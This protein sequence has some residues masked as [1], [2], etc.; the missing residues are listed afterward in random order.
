MN[1][2]FLFDSPVLC[3]RVADRLVLTVSRDG[4]DHPAL[5]QHPLPVDEP[6][7]VAID[8]DLAQVTQAN[9]VLIGW[10]V[11]LV[12]L[13]GCPVTLLNV[14]PRVGMILRRMNLHALMTI[15]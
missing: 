13:C 14:A 2:A 10:L 1:T 15:A 7:I 9:S 11:R 6:G 3:E 8:V 4:A 5:A 12:A